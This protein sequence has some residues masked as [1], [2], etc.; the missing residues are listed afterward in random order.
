ML[1]VNRLKFKVSFFDSLMCLPA[2]PHLGSA[3]F[4]RW[5]DNQIWFIN[6]F[7]VYKH[8]HNRIASFIQNSGNLIPPHNSPLKSSIEVSQKIWGSYIIIRLCFPRSGMKALFV[9][10]GLDG[11]IGCAYD[12]WSGGRGCGSATVFRGNWS[13]NIFYSHSLPSPDSRRAV[14]SFRQKNVHNTG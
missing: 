1:S 14:V 3:L 6:Y 5:F 7:W 9:E 4:R 12:W 10:A 2:L 13:W 8:R 11:S